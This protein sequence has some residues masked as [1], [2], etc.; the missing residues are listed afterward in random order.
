VLSLPKRRAKKSLKKL[1][2]DAASAADLRA[3]TVGMPLMEELNE[4]VWHEDEII[5]FSP[6]LVDL[7]GKVYKTMSAGLRRRGFKVKK[8][9]EVE[10][11]KDRLVSVYRYLIEG[12]GAAEEAAICAKLNNLS[13]IE[14]F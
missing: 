14:S 9:R 7:P 13:I 12:E 10:L 6:T 3:M 1:I 11:R 5:I 4:L 8:Q 2:D